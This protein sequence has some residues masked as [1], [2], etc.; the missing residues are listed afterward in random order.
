MNKIAK[1]CIFVFGFAIPIIVLSSY[2][3]AFIGI[4]AINTLFDASIVM[5]FR[6]WLAFIILLMLSRSSLTFRN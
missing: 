2:V 6:T 5:T 4:W 3:V 1:L